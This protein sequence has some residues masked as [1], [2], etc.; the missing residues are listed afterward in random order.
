MAATFVNIPAAAILTMLEQAGFTE[1]HK[2]R[3]YE[4]V[5]ERE[6]PSGAAVRVYTTLY[7]GGASPKGRGKDRIRI[8]PLYCWRSDDR[9]HWGGVKKATCINRASKH[10]D[11]PEGVKDV[12]DRTVVR[13]RQCWRFLSEGQRA[14]AWWYQKIKGIR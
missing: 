5:F 9:L 4:R 2:Q 10:G 1:N 12:L 7:H 6:H 14:N 11:T 8:L 13:M 3:C